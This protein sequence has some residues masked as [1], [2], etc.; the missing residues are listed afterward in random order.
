M[1]TGR[2][3][4]KKG[5]IPWNKGTKGL[6]KP[7][8]GSFKKGK[9]PSPETEIKKG[10]HLSAKTEFKKGMKLSQNMINALKGKPGRA[11]KGGKTHNYQGRILVSFHDHPFCGSTGYVRRSRLVAE[12]FLKRFLLKS[13]VVHH[14][15]E[16]NTDDRPENLFIFPSKSDH[17]YFHW[18]PRALVSNLL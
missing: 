18:H 17:T 16:D 9:R 5:Q 6:I 15:N 14:I 8:S 11:W 7:N 12:E 1:N 3:H 4:F 2:T 13:E 10:Q